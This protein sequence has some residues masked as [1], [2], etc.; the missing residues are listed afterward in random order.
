MP[1]K[2]NPTQIEALTM[3]CAQVFGNQQSILFANSNGH[4][5]LNVYR[6]L[7]LYNVIQSQNLLGDSAFSFGLRCVKGLKLGKEKI[8][9]N[10]KKNL[11]VVT[12]LNPVI[13][14]SRAAKVAKYAY[15]NGISLRQGLEKLEPQV[16]KE[17]DQ[18]ID[19]S[20]M[21]LP[22]KLK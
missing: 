22:R 20:K 14:Y 12:A 4:L 21:T 1:G 2:V 19:I 11:M 9:E 13:G 5:Q 8:N 18:K 15:E 3:I 16:A 7:V 6:P 17:Y 10:M